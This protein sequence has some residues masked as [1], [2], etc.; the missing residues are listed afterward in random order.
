MNTITR[1]AAPPNSEPPDIPPEPVAPN[2]IPRGRFAAAGRRRLAARLRR[3]LGQLAAAQTD[4][5]RLAPFL[6]IG[7]LVY[8]EAAAHNVLQITPLSM[9]EIPVL[10]LIPRLIEEYPDLPTREGN[11]R[12]AVVVWLEQ[13]QSAARQPQTRD[14]DHAAPRPII[15]A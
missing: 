2:V 10:W 6:E 13:G 3:L 4:A 7:R 12:D 11:L 9:R 14:Y 8:Q 1:A 5:G 15:P